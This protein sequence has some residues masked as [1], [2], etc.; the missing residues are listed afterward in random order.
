MPTTPLICTLALLIAATQD[1]PPPA[2]E[3]PAEEGEPALEEPE[4][5]ALVGGIVH[6]Q[7]EGREPAVRTVV[8]RDRRIEALLEPGTAP[9]EDAHTVDVQGLHLVP[10]LI[11]GHVNHD[12]EHDNLYVARGVTLV[13]DVG[14]TVQDVVQMR[15]PAFRELGPGPDLF[16]CG[17][18]LTGG[19]ERTPSTWPLPHERAAREVLPQKLDELAAQ[20]VEN[21]REPDA[22]DFDYLYFRPDL[23]AEVAEALVEMAHGRDLAVWGPVPAGGS[24]NGV[25][26]SGQDGLVTLGWLLPQGASWSDVTFDDHLQQGV[27]A[28]AQGDVAVT[29]LLATTARWL[30]VPR[31]LE[32]WLARLNPMYEST[33]R[34]FARGVQSA[35]PEART[36]VEGRLALQ[37]QAVHALWKAGVPLVPGSG[38]PFPLLFPGEA[39]IDE[40]DQWIAAGIPSA[41]VLRL[42]TAG[43]ADELGIGGERGRIAP[44]YVADLVALGTDPRDGSLASFRD[45]ELVLVRGRLLERWDL[46]D[47]DQALVQAQAEA[48]EELTRPLDIE[49]PEM[50]VGELLLRGRTETRT[51]GLRTAAERFAVVD[52]LDGR[53]AYGS[54][55]VLPGTGLRPEQHVHLVQVFEGARLESF[56]L[57]AEQPEEEDALVW[58][59]E[60]LLAGESNRMTI[61][62]KHTYATHETEASDRPIAF[63]DFSDTLTALIL[64][65]HARAGTLEEPKAIYPVSFEGAA[66]EPVQDQWYAGVDSNGAVVAQSRHSKTRVLAG[67]DATG[68]PVAFSRMVAGSVSELHLDEDQVEGPG[69]PPAEGRVFDPPEPPK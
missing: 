52:L 9:P 65:R 56:E 32:A 37:R 14:N 28:V 5:L 20:A 25:L 36:L 1:P 60:G 57:R 47:R 64:G 67:L 21:E 15:L 16:I 43:A 33:W 11:D 66:W 29:P 54:R 44:G 26:R 3:E 23:K 13:R 42:A 22:Y 8:V 6:S 7:V 53:T 2:G 10:G 40:L 55:M 24:L 38:T 45:P 62:R 48:R 49:P 27:E 18:A 63:I 12:P 19:D 4:L 31:E 58:L 68:L 51:G 17:P 35:G 46:E 61:R 50:P 34:D 59:I 39:L 69:A 41:E 30:G